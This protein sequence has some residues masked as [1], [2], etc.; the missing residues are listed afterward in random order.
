MAE[1]KTQKTA[2]SVEAF[3]KT[4]D[5]TRRAD[6]RA[7]VRIM[8]EATGA[9]PTM[10][11]TNIVGFGSYHYKYDSGR[12]GEWFI[13]GF[14]PRKRDLTLYIMPGVGRY[15]PLLARLGPHKTGVSC[16]YLKR[17][18]DVDTTVLKELVSAAVNTLRDRRA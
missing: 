1:L 2:A 13:T 6:C 4:L 3:L 10:W 12:A 9:K 8:R 7:L 17:L 18:A 11:G 5:D 14:S 15:K 16:L